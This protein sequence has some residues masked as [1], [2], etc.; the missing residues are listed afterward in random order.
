MIFHTGK[1]QHLRTTFQEEMRKV[2]KSQRTGSGFEEVYEPMWRFLKECMCFEEVILSSRPS[3]TN[4]PVQVMV[5]VSDDVS[6][7][8][9]FGTG[10]GLSLPSLDSSTPLKR[11]QNIESEKE[12][13]LGWKKLHLHS[14]T[15]HKMSVSANNCCQR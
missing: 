6:I 13:S 5:A 7:D 10:E 3:M 2:K 1:I 12:K 4:M 8:T 9:L 11:E 14:Q 15:L